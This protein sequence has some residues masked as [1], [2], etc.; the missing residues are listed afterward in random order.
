MTI[1]RKTLADN[2]DKPSDREPEEHNLSF[3][4]RTKSK[5]LWCL[6][7]NLILQ[8]LIIAS[9]ITSVIAPPWLTFDYTCLS[10]GEDVT[11]KKVYMSIYLA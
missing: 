4:Q 1:E 3:E 5:S 6:S 9:A 10:T 7:L 2:T 8:L 11:C